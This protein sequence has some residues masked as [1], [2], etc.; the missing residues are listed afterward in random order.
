V[1]HRYGALNR[2]FARVVPQH[3]LLGTSTDELEVG[4]TDLLFGYVMGD[5]GCW[6]GTI[7][8]FLGGIATGASTVGFLAITSVFG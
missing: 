4:A 6:R 8:D 7:G 5:R 3:G 2:D 1:A